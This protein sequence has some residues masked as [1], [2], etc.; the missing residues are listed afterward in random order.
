MTPLRIAVFG[1]PAFAVPTLDA[2]LT[3]H[4]QVVGVVTQPDR[5]RG[6]GQHVTEAPMKERARLAG[7]P[8]LQPTRLK[9][10]EFL[11]AFRAWGADI[12]VV[13]AYGRLLPQVLIDM[14]PR[15]LINV[16]AS[17]LPAW[18]GASPIQRAVL[19]GDAVTGVTIMRVVLALDAGAMLARVEVPIEPAETAGALESRLAV[20]GALL[21][22]DVIDRMGRGEDVPEVP[23]DDTRA[24]LAP[25]IE[26]QDGAIDWTRPAPVL[27]CHV[28]GMQPWPGAFTFVDGQ[29]IVIREASVDERPAGEVEPGGLVAAEG[30]ALIFA[31][32]GGT[33]LRVVGVQPEG[34]RAMT[35]REW[36]AGRRAE[37]PLRAGPTP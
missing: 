36:R 6:R 26:K 14:P 29:R 33:A 3:S 24:T 20:A 35:A 32:G 18:R 11:E 10:P 28:R 13:A 21:L 31:C 4:H 7:V 5:P 16:H 19:N 27:D 22:R 1:T 23:Q 9:D 8:I 17:L 2:L 25:K 12:G 37:R 30:D 34:K 15:G